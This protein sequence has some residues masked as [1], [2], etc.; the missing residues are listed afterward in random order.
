MNEIEQKLWADVYAAEYGR[1]CVQQTTPGG[2]TTV[3]GFMVTDF[4]K[5]A[6]LAAIT[7]VHDLRHVSCDGH[8]YEPTELPDF[9]H[10]QKCGHVRKVPREN[11]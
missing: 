4:R 1:L 8:A 3:D 11:E 10:C 9:Q 5:A 6:K 7:A 2:A